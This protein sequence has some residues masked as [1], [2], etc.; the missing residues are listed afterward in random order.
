MK[1]SINPELSPRSILF[2]LC[3]GEDWAGFKPAFSRS[4]PFAKPFV[5]NCY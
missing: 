3:Q 2:Q 4:L 1:D 5:M